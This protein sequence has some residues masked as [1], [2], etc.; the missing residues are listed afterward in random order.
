MLRVCAFLF[1]LFYTPPVQT[2]KIRRKNDCDLRHRNKANNTIDTRQPQIIA[3][4]K[5]I[6]ETILAM[7][8]RE[9]DGNQVHKYAANCRY[10]PLQLVATPTATKTGKTEPT[11]TPQLLLATNY[12]RL[13]IQMYFASIHLCGTMVRQ[14]GICVV[15]CRV[16]SWVASCRS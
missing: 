14:I 7:P 3:R 1:F 13:P 11:S 12:T 2:P 16:V 4:T 8:L 9:E 10:H 5:L 6:T 15:I